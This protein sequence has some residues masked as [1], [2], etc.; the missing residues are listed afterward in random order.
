MDNKTIHRLI[1]I[2]N[3]SFNYKID[4]QTMDKIDFLQFAKDF[5]EGKTE[6][7]KDEYFLEHYNQEVSS[8]LLTLT[9]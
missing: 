3:E 7:Y 8:I 5:M 1:T 9:N 6:Y 4:F 2:F